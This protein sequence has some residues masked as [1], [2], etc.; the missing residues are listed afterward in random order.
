MVTE[1]RQKRLEQENPGLEEVDGQMMPLPDVK[2]QCPTL[3]DLRPVYPPNL[4][5]Y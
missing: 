5:L 4:P 1:L 2:F 3:S